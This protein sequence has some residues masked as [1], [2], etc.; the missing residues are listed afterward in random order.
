MTSRG[1]ESTKLGGDFALYI[2][3]IIM[4]LVTILL[5]IDGRCSISFANNACYVHL[6]FIICDENG[7]KTNSVLYFNLTNGVPASHFWLKRPPKTRHLFAL[8]VIAGA[9]NQ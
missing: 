9:D 7:C 6:S 5:M 1:R 4:M 8:S 3:S 2:T